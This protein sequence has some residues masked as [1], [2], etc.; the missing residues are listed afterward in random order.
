MLDEMS[1]RE[2]E[3]PICGNDI[4]YNMFGLAAASVG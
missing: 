2:R 1:M 3:R 4:E